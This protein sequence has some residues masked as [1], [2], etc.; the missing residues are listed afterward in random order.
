MPG[1]VTLLPSTRRALLTVLTVAVGLQCLRVLF[2]VG[3]TYRE[4]HGITSTAL[5]VVFAFAA[6]ALVPILAR[7]LPARA[8]LI[9]AVGTLAGARAA[10]QVADTVGMGLAVVAAAIALVAIG[11]T[12]RAADDSRLAALAVVG[13]LALDTAL[14]AAW[15]TWDL[16]WQDA[17]APVVAT[18]VLLVLLVAAAVAV[19]APDPEDA[20]PT[21]VAVAR[22]GLALGPFLALQVLL[23]QNLGAVS[24]AAGIALATATAVVLL[25]D[26]LAVAAI[27]LTDRHPQSRSVLVV[28]TVVLAT[29]SWLAT[30][31]GGAAMVI[32]VVAGQV[33]AVALLVRATSRAPDDAAP[34][35]GPET[36]SFALGGLLLGVTLFLYQLHYD[37]PLPFSNRWL[38]VMAAVVLGITAVRAAR[39]E[40]PAPRAAPSGRALIAAGALVVVACVLVAGVAIGEPDL[41]PAAAPSSLRVVTFNVHNGV[42][43][44]GRI[45]LDAIADT[46]EQLDPDVLVVQEAG[47]GWLLSSTTDLA[48]WMKRRLGMPYRWAPAADRQMGNLV[49]SRVPIRDARTVA[50]PQ[51]T[52]TMRRSGLIVRVGPVAGKDVTVMGAHLQNGSTPDRKQTRIEET[53]V[54]LDAWGGAPR[55]VF[56]GDFNMDP[57]ERDLRHVLRS[58]FTTT[59][60]TDECTLKTSNDNCVDW[61]LVTDDLEQGVTR[62]PFVA[63]YDHNP[64]MARVRPR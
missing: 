46:V 47:R 15:G 45:D 54:L 56:A 35:L 52:G 8:G 1:S 20:R 53:D 37:R 31:A 29:V 9:V 55:T 27:D 41:D 23:F 61:I 5:L 4:A 26:G 34:G 42:T 59:Q 25:G 13:G 24:A 64:V 43:R 18:A 44:N 49:F 21:G 11:M 58:G 36:A 16:S 50:L 30:D 14:R 12:V 22:A 2:P 28:A 63:E 33:L 3:Y 48:E 57:G 38:P 10:L 6:P 32:L 62:A 39:A 40:S 7:R 51:A 19:P 60:P 17:A